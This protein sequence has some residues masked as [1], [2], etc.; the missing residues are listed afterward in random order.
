MM[1]PK[2]KNC[3]ACGSKKS[4]EVVA[5]DDNKK[6]N[7][8][9]FSEL[10][11]NHLIDGWLEKFDVAIDGCLDCGHHWYREQPSKEMLSSMYENGVALL[12]Q[13]IADRRQ[14]TLQ[15]IKEMRRLK[16]LLS[17]SAPKLLDYGSGFGRWARAASSVGFDVT[18]YEPSYE[19]GSEDIDIEFTLAHDVT[20]LENQLY[21]VIN[22]EQ[23]LEHVPD[24]LE[25]LKELRV[26][27]KPNTILRI[28]VPNIL[29]C[30]EGR[31]IWESWPY[32][33]CRVHTMAPFE[34]LQGFT[35]L[36]LKKVAGRAGFKS[37][38]NLRVWRRYPTE[39]VRSYA[40]KFFPKLGHTFLLL[41]IS[42]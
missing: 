40:G 12:P 27:C 28:A 18:A 31:H 23:V 5:L 6:E 30:P 34:H 7:Y 8:L 2:I 9:K 38:G 13:S 42:G 10:K 11:Y 3:P 25:L 15:M 35:P 19:R 20:N 4:L 36:S 32:D 26:Y 1:I 41:K 21:D 29:R 33:G 22:L 14:P 16:R 17:P 39:M 24:P 37:V